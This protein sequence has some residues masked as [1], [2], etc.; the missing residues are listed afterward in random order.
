MSGLTAV[1]SLPHLR[2]WLSSFPSF[3]D[4]DE[5]CPF[6]EG[7]S[8]LENEPEE[9]EPPETCSYCDGIPV[10][11]AALLDVHL[12]VSSLQAAL[13]AFRATTIRVA[14]E[15]IN[16]GLLFGKTIFLD[17]YRSPEPPAKHHVRVVREYA[18][19]QLP[20]MLETT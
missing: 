1:I 11:L 2:G 16:G 4:E 6:C 20:L 3:E 15:R 13:Y 19:E 12:R 10:A 7:T 14:V 8:I 9:N 17:R 18:H 5:V